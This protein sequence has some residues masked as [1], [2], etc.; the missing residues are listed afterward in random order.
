MSVS[1]RRIFFLIWWLGGGRIGETGRAEVGGCTD[2]EEEEWLGGA[3]DTGDDGT[4]EEFDLFSS[5]FCWGCFLG[6][7]KLHLVTLSAP[8]MWIGPGGNGGG[9]GTG[10]DA[11][12]LDFAAVLVGVVEGFLDAF[13][14][15]A[16]WE[17]FLLLEETF[18]AFAGEDFFFLL[19]GVPDTED[20]FSGDDIGSFSFCFSSLGGAGNQ[21]QNPAF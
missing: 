4:L 3:E 8:V 20:D 14:L 15:E 2:L 16:W 10:V 13:E 7:V 18:S 17:D 9:A 11:G 19:L 1:E 6:M 12:F 5:S 21:K